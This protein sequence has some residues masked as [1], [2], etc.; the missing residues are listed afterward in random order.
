VVVLG[1]AMLLWAFSMVQMFWWDSQ[2]KHA[3]G[4]ILILCFIE[5]EIKH[6]YRVF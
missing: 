2:D 1:M 5:G 3:V 6:M 4:A